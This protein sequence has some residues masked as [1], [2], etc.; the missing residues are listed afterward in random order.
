MKM[1]QLLNGNNTI[2]A[3]CGSMELEYYKREGGT[4]PYD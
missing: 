3:N 4:N 1:T 2:Y